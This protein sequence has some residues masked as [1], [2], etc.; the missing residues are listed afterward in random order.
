ME[1]DKKPSIIK[2]ALSDYNTIMEAANANAKKK[3]VEEFPEKFDKLLKEELNKNKTKKES[4]KKLDESE[5]S[6][7]VDEIS[8]NE[9]SVMKEKVEETSKVVSKGEPF[10]KGVKVSEDVKITDTVGDSQPFDKKAKK[11]EIVE[12][13]EKSFMGDVE[14]DTPNKGE[15]EAQKGNRFTDKIGNP[16]VGKPISNLE[17][18]YDITELDMNSVASALDEIEGNDEIITLDEID[19]EIANMENLGGELDNAGT[20]EESTE[21]TGIEA[22]TEETGEENA[23][24]IGEETPADKIKGMI[25]VLQGLL[26]ELGGEET[27]ELQEEVLDASNPEGLKNYI[28]QGFAA[29]GEDAAKIDAMLDALSSNPELLYNVY[30]TIKDSEGGSEETTMTS[31]GETAITEEDIQGVVGSAGELEEAHGMAY[32]SRRNMAGR[33]LPGSEY[34][35]K[36]EADQSPAALQEAKTKINGLIAEN[37][38]LTKKLNESKKFKESAT[39]L[40]EN[41]KN[42]LEKYRTQLKEMAIFNTNLAHVNNL[43]VNEELALTQEDKLNIIKEFKQAKSINESQEMYKNLLSEMKVN[44]KTISESLETK[45][46]TSIQPS[47]KQKL[48]EVVEKTAYA[49]NEHIK[50]MQKLM[51]FGEKKR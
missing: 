33:S 11:G 7:T 50:K 16:S 24:E 39:N 31:F 6:T 10:N 20:G 38:K 22:S 45:V 36:G 2:E 28:K 32:S 35:G 4:Y 47:S 21:E 40:V 37:K 44:K 12:E 48:D 29:Q 9:E 1:K 25:E 18:E 5:E 42:A 17:E 41:Y 27:E 19:D 34:L 51:F 23:E 43:L 46:S 30:L 49:N 14:G 3:L 15:G 26:G 13:R 8:N